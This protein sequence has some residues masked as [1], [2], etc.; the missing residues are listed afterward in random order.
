VLSTH[1]IYIGSTY[2]YISWFYVKLEALSALPPE[3]LLPSPPTSQHV[4]DTNSLILGTK[5]SCSKMKYLTL[6]FL[7]IHFTLF[8]V[9]VCF[10][11]WQP[12]ASVLECSISSLGGENEVIHFLASPC[13]VALSPRTSIGVPDLQAWDFR[14]AVGS[15]TSN[16]VLM[17][18]VHSSTEVTNLLIHKSVTGRHHCPKS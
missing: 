18:I 3:T 13:C 6:I 7:D 1:D 17:D 15:L 5:F 12:D 10:V 11:T 14:T 8:A 16:P 9:H 2:I 4:A